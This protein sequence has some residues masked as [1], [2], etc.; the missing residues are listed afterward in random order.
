MFHCFNILSRHAVPDAVK[1]K[2]FAKASRQDTTLEMIRKWLNGA[3]A[4]DIGQYNS[5]KDELSVTYDDM[6]LRGNRLCVP[7]KL[8]ATIIDI[9]HQGHQEM[10]RTKQLLRKYVW[11]PDIDELLRAS[12]IALAIDF[13]G[14]MKNGKYKLIFIDEYSRYPIIKKLLENTDT[15][16]EIFSLFGIPR[17]IKS[18]NGPPFD[19]FKWKEFS[20]EQGFRIHRITPYLLRANGLCE[21]YMRNLEKVKVLGDV[22]S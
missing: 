21:H 20:K 6:V 18:D 13:Y 15:L 2:D 7:K 12:S 10:V 8:Q 5:I 17:Q 9:V 16:I 11:F 3:R 1:R 19:G 14:P 4:G 22:M